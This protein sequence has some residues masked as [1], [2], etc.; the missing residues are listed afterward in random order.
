MFLQ[1]APSLLRA[2]QPV[3]L[4]QAVQ[5]PS[6]VPELALAQTLGDDDGDGALSG[7]PRFLLRMSD[8]RYV[9]AEYPV[10]TRIVLFRPD[11]RLDR[12]IGRRGEG[13]G[14]FEFIRAWLLFVDA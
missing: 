8:G 2:Q 10:A 3:R 13:P 12:V 9:T 11:G 14:E 4:D 1:V 5:C 7:E 6:C